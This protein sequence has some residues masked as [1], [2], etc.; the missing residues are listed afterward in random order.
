MRR[1]KI[2]EDLSTVLFEGARPPSAGAQ[3]M[4]QQGNY[5][6]VPSVVG[7]RGNET[8]YNNKAV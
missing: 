5:F 2:N 1:G 3:V 8:V 7:K 6:C 4:Q